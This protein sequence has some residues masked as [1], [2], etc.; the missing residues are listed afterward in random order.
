M[1]IRR[2]FLRFRSTVALAI[3]VCWF[4]ATPQVSAG[5]FRAGAAMVD[6][7]PKDGVPMAGYYRFRASNGVLD[8]I[9]SRTVVVEQDGARAAF[10]VLDMVNTTRPVVEAARKLIAEQH[11]IPPERVMISATHTHTAPYIVRNS[12]MDDVTKAKLPA[13]LEYADRLP[14]WISQS[15]G[16]AIAKLTPAKASATVGKAEGISFNRRAIGKDG[17][18]IWQPKKMDPNVLRP[19]G[20]IDPDLGL[21]VFEAQKVQA[22]PLATYVNFAM[23]PTSIGGGNRVSSDYPGALCRILC[24]RKGKDMV[25]IF[26]NG[27]CGNINH[28]NYLSATPQASGLAETN[29][30]GTALADAA[31]R[32]W[33]GLK[34]LS[35]GAPR[36]KSTMVRLE[37]R[38]FTEEQVT[39]AK[40]VAARMF[41]EKLGTVPMAEA[42]CILDTVR[43]KDTPLMAEV[44]VIAFSDEL[45]VVSLPGEIF[46]ELGLAIKAASPFKH[47]FIAELANGSIGYIPNRDAYPQGNYEVV[48][49]RCEVGSGEKLAET[50]IA[51]LKEVHGQGKSL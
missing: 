37:R 19:A 38:N 28:I 10:V 39:R 14:V 12:M 9:Y 21:L 47:T 31:E 29:R 7:T 3:A 42:V 18:L 23:H 17:S 8:P 40:D 43:L 33:S 2:P 13:G 35:I 4:A 20:P 41:T 24:E 26:A 44:Q 51:L 30:L 34:E 22:S 5:E 6:I 25:A 1:F 16:D 48:S 27:C 15:V 11:G 36:A 32:A 46:V 49:A 50:A 45:A